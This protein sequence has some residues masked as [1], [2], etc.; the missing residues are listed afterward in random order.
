MVEVIVAVEE[1]E[2]EP[3]P[4]VAVELEPSAEE[5]M[6][7]ALAPVVLKEELP[8]EAEAIASVKVVSG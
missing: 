3:A 6:D 8:E 1:A 2:P 7:R 5:R 4:S